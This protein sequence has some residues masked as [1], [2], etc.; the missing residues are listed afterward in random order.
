M[1]YTTVLNIQQKG[2]FEND[3]P[4][5]MFNKVEDISPVGLLSEW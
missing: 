5:S 3:K 2:G 1:V 4:T